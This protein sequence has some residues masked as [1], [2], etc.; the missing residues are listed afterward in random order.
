MPVKFEVATGTPLVTV[1]DALAA[2]SRILPD[3]TFRKDDTG[4]ALA[5]SAK[6]VKGKLRIGGQEH[7]YLEGQVS[8]AIPGEDGDMLIHTS[9][10]HPSEVQ[11]LIAGMLKVPVGHLVDLIW[12]HKAGLV[13]FG[14]LL[15]TAGLLIMV[16]LIGV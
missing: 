10:Q 6:R 9:S 4:F 3:Y 16:G 7:F 14:A 15:I 13:Y 1:D 2:N 5:A 12:R 11:H 8:L